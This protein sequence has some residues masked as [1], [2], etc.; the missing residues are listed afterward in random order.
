[1]LTYIVKPGDT[2]WAIARRYGVKT[3]QQL[4]HDP[5]NTAFR[6]KRPNPNLIYPGDKINIPTPPPKLA[7]GK[8]HSKPGKL[9]PELERFQKELHEE[10]A[11]D[12]QANWDEFVKSMTD[13]TKW[14]KLTTFIAGRAGQARQIALL[15]SFVRGIGLPPSEVTE[16]LKTVFSDAVDGSTA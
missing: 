5:A 3:W 2:L 11:K 16:V 1:M 14:T 4:Y 8:E 9:P 13:L 15:Y 10:I 6:A 7:E 12:Q